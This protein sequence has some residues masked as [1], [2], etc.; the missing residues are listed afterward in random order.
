MHGS[1]RFHVID[2]QYIV[3]RRGVADCQLN[4]ARL[5]KLSLNHPSPCTVTAIHA[6]LLTAKSRTQIDKQS[7]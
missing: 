5:N 6:G 4:C 1:V 2:I 3:R 7:A